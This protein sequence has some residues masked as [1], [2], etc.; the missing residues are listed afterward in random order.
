MEHRMP[1][2]CHCPSCNYAY[3]LNDQLAGQD[4][5]CKK[6]GNSFVVP[7]EAHAANPLDDDAF[8]QLLSATPR[9]LAASPKPYTPARE[10]NP[11]LV[12]VGAFA[13]IAGAILGYYAAMM[14]VIPGGIALFVGLALGA[15]LPKPR[16]VLATPAAILVGHAGWV[17]VGYLSVRHEVEFELAAQIMLYLNIFLPLL[18]AVWLIARPSWTAVIVIGVLEL[19]M[20]VFNF[21]DFMQVTFGSG[22]HR[23]LSVHLCL[24]LAIIGLCV[25]CYFAYRKTHDNAKPAFPVIPG[26][27]SN[28]NQ[29]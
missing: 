27:P 26:G 12:I 13:G 9:S 28:L 7:G 24:R 23:A 17:L 29:S 10:T 16:K 5:L 22:M 8:Q 14:L 21:I 2:S 15:T 20:I 6:C 1:V 11:L 25:G 18:L 4:I 3:S 19:V